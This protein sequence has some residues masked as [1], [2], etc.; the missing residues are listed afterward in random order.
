[1]IVEYIRYRVAESD[2]EKLVEAYEKAA[3]PLFASGHC[4]SFEVTRCVDE[5]EVFVVRIEWDSA[6]GHLQGFRTG[7]QFPAFF[8]LVRPFAQSIEEM[9]HYEVQTSHAGA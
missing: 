8:A 6:E 5:P 3:Q 1:M 2:G 9:R 7:P 4:R